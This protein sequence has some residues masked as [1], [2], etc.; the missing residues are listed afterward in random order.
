MKKGILTTQAVGNSG[1]NVTSVRSVAPWILSVAASTIDRKFTNKIILGDN[2]TFVNDAIETFEAEAPLVYGNVSLP[3]CPE[4]A[5]RECLLFC[6]DEK[7]VKGKIVVCDHPGGFVEAYRTG[8][9][10]SISPSYSKFSEA[11]LPNAAYALKNHEGDQVKAYMKSTKNPQAKILKSE[12]VKSVGDPITPNFSSRGPSAIIADIIK[13]D[14]SAPGVGILAEYPPILP[15]S[16][17]HGQDKRSV[18]YNLMIGTSVA[19]AHAA[20]AA[21]YVKSFHPDWSPSSVKSALLTTVWPMNSTSNPDGEF[22]FGTGHIDPVKA[23]SPGLV[24]EAFEDD[25]V[26]FLCSIGYTTTE[27]RS[28]TG[29]DS[30][31]QGRNQD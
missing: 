13:P 7:L 29:D 6:L 11:P 10:G 9:T 16:G 15:T 2:T 24:Y 22:G 25:Y 30:S 20:G 19:C 27:L 31:C 21:A 5:G 12:V 14:I 1:P 4:S 8:A 18:K 23:I 26:K 28:I 3:G 17:L